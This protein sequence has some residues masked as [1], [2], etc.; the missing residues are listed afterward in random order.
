MKTPKILLTECNKCDKKFSIWNSYNLNGKYYCE[1]C[2][3][4]YGKESLMKYKPKEEI[5]AEKEA[6]KEKNTIKEY[7]RKCNQCGKI[8]HSEVNRE[9]QISSGNFFSALIGL[10]STLQGK[11]GDAIQAYRNTDAQADLLDK[12]KKCPN[13]G[14][15][16]YKE[17]II[18]Y[19]KQ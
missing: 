14:S 3:K 8:W 19:K 5:Y 17:E 4:K 15:K 16:D 10:G 12:L 13:C 2:Y 18:S 11:S 6:E 7:K 9:E 1:E